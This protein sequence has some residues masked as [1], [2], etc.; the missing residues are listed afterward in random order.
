MDF[1]KLKQIV[2]AGEDAAHQFKEDISNINSL[3]AEMAAFSN[4]QGGVVLIG[5]TDQGRISGLLSEDVRR[6][7][8]LISNAASQHVKSP[9]SVT[10]ENISISP[11]KA[12]I[13]LKVPEGID[14]PYFDN[15]G[16]IWLKN[17]ADKRR[18]NSKEELRRL[19]QTMDSVYADEVPTKVGVEAL[20]RKY[21]SEFMLKTYGE[22]LPK[23]PIKLLKLLGNINLA[24]GDK[25]NLAGLLLFG[26]K[27]QNYKPQFSIKA[28]SFLGNEITSSYMDSEDFEG[29]L[30]SMFKEA[31]SF[32]RRHLKKIQGKKSVNSVG[33]PEIP[34]I[35][36]EELLV[37]ALTH[38]DYFISAPIRIF[39]FD[40]R[41]EIISPGALP[42][43][44]T[45]EKIRAGN[46]VQRNPILSS[47]IAKGL[48]PYRGLGSG[49]MRSLQDWP[50]ITFVDDREGGLF[51]SII[52]RNR[53]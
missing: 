30:S 41:I 46:S 48:L 12:V 7:N 40:N 42:N 47:F 32:I 24:M 10:T 1:K 2:V 9:I 45:V 23:T 35:V 43:H 19:F 18:I 49:I 21:L 31:L 50:K 11:R 15:Q 6:I 34:Y 22:P 26:E 16:I 20:D 52:E 4:A 25:L 44:L 8:Q 13:V 14:K 53:A 33:D 39:V 27:P 36:F 28:A 37:N 17:G 51:K 29:S 38:R 3:A 5:V